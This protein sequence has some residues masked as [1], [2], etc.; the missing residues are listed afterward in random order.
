MRT[1]ITTRGDH[2]GTFTYHNLCSTKERSRG[3]CCNNKN[4]SGNLLD[5][6][7]IEEIKKLSEDSGAFMTRL[8]Q[9]KKELV[10]NSG[11]YL[12]QVEK[13]QTILP[14]K[15]KENKARKLGQRL[16]AVEENHG[17]KKERVAQ[18]KVLHVLHNGPAVVLYLHQSQEITLSSST[19]SLKDLLLNLRFQLSVQKIASS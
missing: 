4:A 16:E 15:H 3:H 7:I 18:D 14:D 11:S 2:Y 9:S 1:Q 19:K 6:A 13:L 8:E 12:D 5:Q 10:V 17:D